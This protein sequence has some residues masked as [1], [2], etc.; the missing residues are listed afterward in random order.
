MANEV[1]SVTEFTEE[2]KRDAVELTRKQGLSV[3]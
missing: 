1:S 2:F 3:A